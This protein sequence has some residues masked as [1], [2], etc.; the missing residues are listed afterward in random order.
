MWQKLK[1]IRSRQNQIVK[2]L[3]ALRNER[4]AKKQGEML[5][6]GLRQIETAASVVEPR[7]LIFADDERGETC[8]GSLSQS[9]IRFPQTGRVL[10]VEPAL[11]NQIAQ[12]EHSQ[13]VLALYRAPDIEPLRKPFRDRSRV[14]ILEEI[15]DPGNL[16]TISRTAEAL[17]FDAVVLAG[18][19]VWPYN[20]KCLRASMGAALFVKYYA[21]RELTVLETLLGANDLIVADMGGSGL[22]GFMPSE[23]QKR[24]FALLLGNEARGVSETAK[25]LSRYVLSVEMSG[26]AESLNISAAA[27]ILAWKLSE[28]Y[29]FPG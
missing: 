27:A 15:Q 14:L 5:V 9:G 19:Y 28:C 2:D 18:P 29:R 16:G 13:G 1:L 6:E 25:R 20:A 3:L 11:Y 22:S 26:H 4:T 10:R 21:L 24:G 17:G 7:M 8:F 23:A 12:T